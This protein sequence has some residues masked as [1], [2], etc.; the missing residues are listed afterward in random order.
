MSSV[1]SVFQTSFELR[2]LAYMYVHVS[3][4]L[5]IKRISGSGLC[6]VSIPHGQ[7]RACVCIEL[8]LLYIVVT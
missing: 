8:R 4:Y 6:P 5:N 3:L 2:R 1:S 7:Q